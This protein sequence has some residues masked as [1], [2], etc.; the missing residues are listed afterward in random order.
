MESC[1]VQHHLCCGLLVFVSF[2]FFLFC[3]SPLVV[4][5]AA[6]NPSFVALYAGLACRAAL[7]YYKEHAYSVLPPIPAFDAAE[8]AQALVGRACL[9]WHTGI[10]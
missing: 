3:L 8:Q 9:G 2:L 4:W 10:R 7:R 1:E 6:A 5:D